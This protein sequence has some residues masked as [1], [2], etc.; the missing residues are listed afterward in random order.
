MSAC[1][2]FQLL[3]VRGSL[4]SAERLIQNHRSNC[5]RMA[6]QIMKKRGQCQRLE[7]ELEALHQQV[8]TSSSGIHSNLKKK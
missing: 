7:Q 6:K 2:R 8:C 4:R 3:V 1:F 5:R